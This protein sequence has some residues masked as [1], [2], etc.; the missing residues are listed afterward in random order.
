M[1][2]LLDMLKEQ[3]EVIAELLKQNAEIKAKQEEQDEVLAMLL[4]KMVEE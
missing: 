4:L 1:K 2:S 3:E